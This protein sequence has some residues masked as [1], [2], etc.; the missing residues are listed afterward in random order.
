MTHIH[1]LTPLGQSHHH[2]KDSEEEEELFLTTEPAIIF[3]ANTL[4]EAVPSSYNAVRIRL[5]A[6]L[7]SDLL[8]EKELLAAKNYVGQGLKIF[9]DL[10]FGFAETN[11]TL[12]NQSQFLSFTLALKHFQDTLWKTFRSH[13]VGLC[14]YR[15]RADFSL[16]FK[17]DEEEVV[18]LQ[19]WIKEVFGSIESFVSETGVNISSFEEIDVSNLSSTVEG[20][21]LIALY[22]RDSF[23][24]YIQLLSDSLPDSL[25]TYILL[26]IETVSDPLLQ[27]QLT[28][29]E[30]Y[31]GICLGVRGPCF[32]ENILAWD[33]PQSYLGVISR[34]LEDPKVSQVNVGV[35]V[36]PIGQYLPSKWNGIREAINSLKKKKIPFRAISEDSLTTEWDGLDTLIVSMESLS[37]QGRRKL[38]G[39]EAAGGVVE[40]VD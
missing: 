40:S 34:Q 16:N 31:T 4:E 21:R 24:R 37:E 6:S 18:H 11:Q 25:Q 12:W 29:H 5:D 27:V 3:D 10:D 1:K 32:N 23:G 35:C 33:G 13:T 2:L 20:S 22:C 7:K 17:W 38:Q 15:G 39:F 8:W 19:E 14:L 30:C 28:T 26:D 9:W 36:L